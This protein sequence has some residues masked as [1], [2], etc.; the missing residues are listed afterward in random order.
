MAVSVGVFVAFGVK[1]TVTVFGMGDFTGVDVSLPFADMAVNGG[2]SVAVG[3]SLGDE[4]F[5]LTLGETISL[6]VAHLLGVGVCSV[7][8]VADGI[9]RLALEHA[10]SIPAKNKAEK[11]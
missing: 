11:K 7:G 5:S 10:R 2:V 6:D 8:G 3:V 9:R 1:V 4:I